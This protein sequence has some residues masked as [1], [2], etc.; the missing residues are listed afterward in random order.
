L[1]EKNIKSKFKVTRI[2]PLSIKAYVDDKTKPSEVFKITKR[3]K[4]KDA[5]FSINDNE[6]T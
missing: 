5:F 6:N 2:W 1:F 3:M 4:N